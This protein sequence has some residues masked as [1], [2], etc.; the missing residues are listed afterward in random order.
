M[1][2]PL[3][4]PV[5]RWAMWAPDLT[6]TT[7]HDDAPSVSFM[8]AMQRRRLS[9]LSRLCLQ[10]AHEAGHSI[11]TLPTVFASRHGELHRTLGL[12]EQL[13][14]A[15][16]LSPMAFSLSVHNTASGLYAIHTG[17]T[18][19]STAVAAGKDTLPMAFLEAA[20]L[21]QSHPAVMLI[22]AE[23]PLPTLYQ[24]FADQPE[25]LASVALLL[26]HH[27][28]GDTLTLAPAFTDSNTTSTA[29]NTLLSW[30]D[31][32]ANARS[33]NSDCLMPGEQSAWR[34]Q[35]MTGTQPARQP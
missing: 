32:L 12:L 35:K 26:G 24:S 11:A 13:S 9:R 25:H 3:T 23:E 17:N 29:D 2:W 19:P 15:E 18:A 33:E 21:L 28:L 8:P 22:Y 4:V 10:V 20:S 27:P 31:W 7:S 1:S 5:A 30:L 14:A 16:P 34:W 6:A